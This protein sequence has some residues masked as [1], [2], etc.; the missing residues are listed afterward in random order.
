MNKRVVG[1][2]PHADGAERAIPAFETSGRAKPAFEAFREG[3][4]EFAQ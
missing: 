2:S 1:A 3:G 4:E